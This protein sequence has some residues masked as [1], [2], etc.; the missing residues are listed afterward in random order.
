MEQEDIKIQR[1]IE[2]YD[3]DKRKLAK[4]DDVV[5]PGGQSSTRK[6]K[7]NDVKKVIEALYEEFKGDA[8]NNNL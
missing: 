8:N 3:Y 7:G 1:I 6:E 4:Q 2:N 5:S